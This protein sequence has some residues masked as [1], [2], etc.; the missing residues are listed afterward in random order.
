MI[1]LSRLL[2]GSRVFGLGT[3]MVLTAVALAAAPQR[4]DGDVLIFAAASLQTALDELVPA[5]ARATGSRVRASYAASS[6]LARQIEHG[7]PADLFIAADLEWMEY[8]S[9]RRLIQPASRINLLGNRLVLIAPTDRP[10]ALKIAP[11]FPLA[12]ALGR[13][14]LALADPASVPAGKYARAALT[15]LGVW[16][17]VAAK[18]AAAENVRAALMLVSRGEAPLGIVYRTDAQIEPRVAVVDTFPETSHPPIVYPAA[19]V[20]T[21]SSGAATVLDFLKSAEAR[22]VFE[23][24]GFLVPRRD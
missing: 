13:D 14:R 1:V 3:L 12:A 22:A 8:V 24:H 19:I 20:T 16:D 6:A 10:S 7:A 23:R 17:S 9:E 5:T 15:A 18:V 11:G 4:P 21:A 2:R